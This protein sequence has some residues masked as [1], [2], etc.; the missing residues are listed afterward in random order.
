MCQLVAVNAD[1]VYINGSDT[2]PDLE[3]EDADF[4]ENYWP[5][6]RQIAHTDTTDRQQQLDMNS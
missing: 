5:K 6:V 2:D 1:P 3:M 4:D